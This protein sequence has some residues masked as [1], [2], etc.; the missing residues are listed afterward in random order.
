MRDV[1]D[2][3]IE[4]DRNVNTQ[5]PSCIYRAY[6]KLVEDHSDINK[7]ISLLCNITMLMIYLTTC[8]IMRKSHEV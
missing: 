1:Y 7:L 2:E 6:S 8:K 3:M 4:S 5:F